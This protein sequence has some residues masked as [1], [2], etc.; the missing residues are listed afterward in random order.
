[1]WSKVITKLYSDPKWPHQEI[2]ITQTDFDPKGSSTN[3]WIQCE[4]QDKLLSKVII[5]RGCDP[6][7]LPKLVVFQSDHPKKLWYKVITQ[8]VFDPKW[9]PKEV[10]IQ[11]DHPKKLWSKV[12]TKRGWDS[13][14]SSKLVVIQSDHPK[15]LWSKTITQSNHQKKFNADCSF[16]C[17]VSQ[18]YH[19]SKWWSKVFTPS[20]QICQ[21]FQKYF[22]RLLLLFF[23]VF[24]E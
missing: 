9:S 14:W 19:L 10:V 8:I 7:L 21:H 15:M 4:H 11:S 3:A 2:R 13:N 20:V 22:Y 1:M 23:Y 5:L 18:K 12:I 24:H 6:K 16:Q 17:G